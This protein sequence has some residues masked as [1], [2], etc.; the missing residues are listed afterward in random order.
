MGI[1]QNIKEYEKV[2]LIINERKNIENCQ[3][4]KTSDS[5]NKCD[6]LVSQ[7]TSLQSSK[8]FLEGKRSANQ[9]EIVVL[10]EKLRKYR[11][12][13][14]NSKNLDN[15]SKVENKESLKNSCLKYKEK[16]SRYY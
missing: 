14:E 11:D 2:E 13:S 16:N 9:C 6:N 12:L 3:K 15:L 10:Q 5:D 4:S 1:S 7:I 8:D